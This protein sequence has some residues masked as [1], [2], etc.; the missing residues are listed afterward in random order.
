MG[1][2]SKKRK[3][4]TTAW[5]FNFMYNGVRYRGVG[6]TTKT[7]GLRTLDKKRSEILNEEYEL[8]SR[9]G[10][11]KIEKFAEI[12]LNR[13]KRLRS[14]NRDEYSIGNLLKFFE[15]KNLSAINP[16]DIEDYIGERQNQGLSNATINRELACL[17]R[18]YSLAIKWHAKK[19]PVKDV[20]FLN[21]PPGR[22]RFLNKEEANWLLECCTEH[23]K[24]IVMVALNTGM[25]L[26]EI[27]ALTWDRVYI[28]HVIDP[29]IELL[30]TKNK[31]PRFVPLNDDTVERLKEQKR[32][33]NV[34]EYV[35][36][37]NHTKPLKSVRTAFQL[38]LKKAGI[39][40]FR[41]HDLRHTFA[42]HFVMNGGDLL[43]LKEIL[44]HSS[45]K[46]VERYIH[47]AAAHKRRQINN[48]NGMF[49]IC[50]PIATSKKVI[51]MS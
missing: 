8:E 13:R 9:V 28:A 15:G 17:K 37:S 33:N 50:H 14:H 2:Y 32:R 22:T 4:G 5:Y 29:Y 44:G 46:M 36:L 42:S 3:D 19:N 51:E 34:S 30:K 18:M 43:T 48:I 40:D 16:S 27:L 26:G 20:E 7:Q 10:N 21:E 31:Q 1:V 41:F 11:P 25:R 23:L 24:P 39:L 35:F 47:L 45:M 6:G 49:S 38:A 12:F